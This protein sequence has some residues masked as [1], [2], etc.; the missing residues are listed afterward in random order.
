M[1]PL[2]NQ[3]SEKRRCDEVNKIVKE[4]IIDMMHKIE[5]QKKSPTKENESRSSSTTTRRDKFCSI[6]P[7]NS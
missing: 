4:V 5:A 2:A 1:I 6:F 3:T 7:K